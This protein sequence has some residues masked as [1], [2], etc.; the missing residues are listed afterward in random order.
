MING[1]TVGY[2]TDQEYLFYRDEGRKYAPD[3][4]LVF[5]YQNDIPYLAQD[6]YIGYPKPRLD[7]STDPP[8]VANEPVPPYEAPPAAAAAA[9]EPVPSYLARVREERAWSAR[10]RAPTTAWPAPASGSRC[11][12]SR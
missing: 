5:V 11:A 1:G 10:P 4:V 12:S 7:F 2:S 3:V 9:P 6:E 8:A